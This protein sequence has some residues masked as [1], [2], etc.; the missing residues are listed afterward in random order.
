MGFLPTSTAVLTFLEILRLYKTNQLPLHNLFIDYKAAFDTVQH[1][2]INTI[3]QHIR[4][5]EPLLKAIN[6][7][8]AST[9]AFKTAYGPTEPLQ[10]KNGVK[11]GDPISPLLFLI[12]LLPLQWTIKSIHPP[13]LLHINHLCYADDLLCFADNPR[14]LNEIFNIIKQYSNLTDVHVNPTKSA[15]LPVNTQPML[16]L[17]YFNIQIPILMPHQSYKYLGLNINANLNFESELNKTITAYKLT[18]NH[19]LTKRYLG[20]KILTRLCNTVALPKLGYIFQLICI[21]TD[22][23]QEI[24]KFLLNS[25]NKCFTIPKN[26]YFPFWNILH[27]LISPSEYAKTKYITNYTVNGFNSPFKQLSILTNY[28]HIERPYSKLHQMPRIPKLLKQ[29]DL[30]IQQ[31]T[32]PQ[33]PNQSSPILSPINIFTDASLSIQNNKG[34]AAYIVPN[35]NIQQVIPPTTPF[36]STYV[37]EQAITK[38]LRNTINYTNV[39]IITDS[40]SALHTIQSFRALPISQQISSNHY[41]FIQTITQ[42][43]ELRKARHFKT[44]FSHVYSHLLDQ[45]K[46]QNYQSKLLEMKRKYPNNYKDLLFGNQLADRL[47]S[48]QAL[49]P[50]PPSQLQYFFPLFTIF[51]INNIP[52]LSIA[53]HLQSVFQNQNLEKLQ[54]NKWYLDSKIDT[55][56]TLNSPYIPF[57]IL[58]LKLSQSMILTKERAYAHFNNK[59]QPHIP[60][61]RLAQLKSI[62]SNIYCPFCPNN[63][64][65]NHEHGSTNC[66]IAQEINQRL[67]NK[68][69]ALFTK[70]A[71]NKNWTFAPWFT[72]NNQFQQLNTTHPL[73][74]FPKNLGD[75]G[76]IPKELTKF[77]TSL[78]PNHPNLLRETIKLTHSYP[79]MC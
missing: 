3:L 5:P 1:W 65:D 57:Q 78:K 28:N 55:K 23:I 18:I 54:R 46:P 38:A 36:Q 2:C 61:Q 27:K 42:L 16:Q 62:Y 10:I 4:I 25:L 21:Q 69:L 60:T 22:T 26:I 51:D 58:F 79:Y 31:T 7:K 40:L 71:T 19:I 35:T 34:S 75:R 14:S 6:S 20:P 77:I 24:D 30:K 41:P 33:P 29:L 17:S 37:E 64:V 67:L 74:N 73:A 45:N 15:Y 66:K 32:P 70:Y 56:L 52:H 50:Q 39:H 11:Q 76:M 68:L 43:I 49:S 59:K 13:Q 12:Y 72:C 8:L 9:T 63:A 44:T 48:S 47:A 53:R